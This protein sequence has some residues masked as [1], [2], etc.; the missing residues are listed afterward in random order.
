MIF[1]VI[2][3]YVLTKS[4][5]RGFLLLIM[6]FSEFESFVNVALNIGLHSIIHVICSKK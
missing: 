2:S 4:K 3:M 5:T 6:N 1:V